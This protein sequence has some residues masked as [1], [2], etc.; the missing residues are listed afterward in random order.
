MISVDYF[1]IADRPT[2]VTNGAIINPATEVPA[3]DPL[4]TYSLATH[5][6][7]VS[8]QFGIQ[9]IRGEKQVM[10]EGKVY[11]FPSP[12]TASGAIGASVG[13]FM[14]NGFSIPTWNKLSEIHAL[15]SN[16]RFSVLVR[17]LVNGFIPQVQID[18]RVLFIGKRIQTLYA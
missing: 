18:I 3:N 16:D 12:F 2:T 6:K 11:Q 10:V 14:Q 17:P 1:P 7:A 8:R 15:K 9:F 13:G 5:Y 4:A